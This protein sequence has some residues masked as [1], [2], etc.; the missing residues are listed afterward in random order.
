METEK[1]QQLQAEINVLTIKNAELGWICDCNQE[2]YET[3]VKAKEEKMAE[4]ASEMDCIMRESVS[5]FVQE[6][7]RIKDCQLAEL[8]LQ[9]EE[10]CDFSHQWRRRAI[11]AEGGSCNLY[12]RAAIHE[13][14]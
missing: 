6:E 11:E 12:D 5:S 7:M 8:R 2:Q 10:A 13:C 9:Y 1:Y 3:E 4:H 14:A